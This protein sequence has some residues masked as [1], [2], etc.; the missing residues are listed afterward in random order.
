MWFSRQEYWSGLPFS[1]PG[2]LP[3]P[4]IEPR[5]P[6]LEAD[7]LPSEP[8]H[9]VL[10]GSARSCIQVVSFVWVLTI[11]YSL[12]L[13]SDS[14]GSWKLLLPLQRLGAW[15]ILHGTQSSCPCRW[16]RGWGGGF[17]HECVTW[18][19]CQ[20]SALAV[21][22]N[23]SSVE[24][25]FQMQIQ[26]QTPALHPPSSFLWNPSIPSTTYDSGPRS[27]LLFSGRWTSPLH[28]LSFKPAFSLSPFTFIKG[29]FSSSLSLAGV[30]SSACLRLL[31]FLLAILIPVCVSSNPAFL[32]MWLELCKQGL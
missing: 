2:D 14:L 18:A 32:M 24:A 27:G 7:T 17:S 13:V 15:Y 11:W 12:R 29:L 21:P 20:P 19:T 31:I 6:A 4:G 16:R 1:S 9:R 10:P 25:T 8:L 23:S 5:S 22:V 28:M 26:S 3:D 30:V